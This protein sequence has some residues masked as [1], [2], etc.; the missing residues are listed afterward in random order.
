MTERYKNMRIDV[1]MAENGIA[2]SR[3]KAQAMI[4]EGAVLLN[5][6]AVTKPSA[7]VTESD[8][9]T[10]TARPEFVSRGGKKLNHALEQFGVNVTEAVCVDIGASTGGFTDCLLKRSAKKV[11]AVDSGKDQLHHL[12]RADSRVVCMEKTNARALTHEALGEKCDVAVMDVSFISQT[13]LYPAVKS[14]LKNGG[15]FISLIK[16]QFEATASALGKGGILRDKKIHIRV[17]EK[18]LTEA[19]KNGLTPL[20]VI[21]SPIEGGDGNREYLAHFIN[22]ETDGKAVSPRLR[23]REFLKGL[24]DGK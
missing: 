7:A 12:L 10:I 13:L 3:S 19:E 17:I 23:D 5:G 4:A 6:S 14:C 1:Y 22:G 15:S 9:V 18:I 8:T 24:T 20:S 16:P 21:P 11:Y 2:E